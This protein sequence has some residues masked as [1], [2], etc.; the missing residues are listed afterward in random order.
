MEVELKGVSASN[1][2]KFEFSV[3]KK[4]RMIVSRRKKADIISILENQIESA[5]FKKNIITMVSCM[6]AHLQKCMAHAIHLYP[7]KLALLTGGKISIETENL[8][9]ASNKEELLEYVVS[10]KCAEAF[11]KSPEEYFKIFQRVMSIE[12]T[13]DLINIYKEIKASRD[14]I[15]HNDSIVNS[16]YITKAG[17]LA[18]QKLSAP[19]TFDSKYYEHVIASLKKLAGAIIHAVEKNYK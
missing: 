18:R 8:L 6:E 13:D 12:I 1:R 4:E 11:F 15:I 19:L 5:I 14:S 7:P 9:A 16:L 3:P 17:S 2:K 10:E